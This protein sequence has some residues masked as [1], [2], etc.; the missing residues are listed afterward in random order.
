[1]AAKQTITTVSGVEYQLRFDVTLLQSTSTMQ[2]C[3]GTTDEGFDLLDTG[4]LD[5]VDSY[6][7]YFTAQSTT[8]YITFVGTMPVSS[9][10]AI[11][12]VSV[13]SFGETG[14]YFQTTKGLPLISDP[15][16]RYTDGPYRDEIT[17]KANANHTGPT[18]RSLYNW[19][20]DAYGLNTPS[21]DDN[22]GSV[23]VE[24]VDRDLATQG[25][26]YRLQTK[27]PTS[28]GIVADIENWTFE[29]WP[30]T[31]DVPADFLI[32]GD[33]IDGTYSKILHNFSLGKV[34]L[35]TSYFGTTTL[36]SARG[37]WTFW[38]KKAASSGIGFYFVSDTTTFLNSYLVYIG[39]TGTILLGRIVSG[40]PTWLFTGSSAISDDVWYKLD[41]DYSASNVISVYLN[42]VLVPVSVG[43]NPITEFYYTSSSYI[44]VNFVNSSGSDLALWD[45]NGNKLTTYTPL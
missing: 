27:G 44:V 28:A 1:M 12:N 11:D 4:Q 17:A 15:T 19:L 20:I 24:I 32:Q 40:T 45:F 18:V 30:W 43:S 31:Y 2:C 29:Y 36:E 35:P 34:Y 23:D 13:R 6:E 33:T 7:Y 22:V 8:T 14:G 16:T 10:A 5:Q 3:V 9:Y 26:R 39:T 21:I 38:F 41:I 42:D 25:Q 37:H